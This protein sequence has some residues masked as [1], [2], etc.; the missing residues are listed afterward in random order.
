[1]DLRQKVIKWLK[2]NPESV[3][4]ESFMI[5][6]SFQ[7]N[8]PLNE[9]GTVACLAGI[10]CLVSK[11]P[12]ITTVDKFGYLND[13]EPGHDAP[14]INYKYCL[15]F[16][17]ETSYITKVARQLWGEAYG[18]KAAKNLP[19][20]DWYDEDGCGME[21]YEVTAQDLIDYLEEKRDLEV[22]LIY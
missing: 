15:D 12:L 11:I 14:E 20:Y 19:F 5:P 7:H 18:E 17:K 22:N 4:M 1:M 8:Q 10:I 13:I 2:E 6:K 16:E 21:L 9:C 3:N